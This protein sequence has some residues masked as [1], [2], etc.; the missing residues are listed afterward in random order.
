MSEV[1]GKRYARRRELRHPSSSNT[2]NNKRPN[3]LKDSNK[4]LNRHTTG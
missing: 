4:I 2:R 1:D 3:I